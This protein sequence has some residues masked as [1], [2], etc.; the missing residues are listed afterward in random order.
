M[1]KVKDG[2]Q[3]A[4]EGSSTI[5]DGLALGLRLRSLRR[6]RRLTL[7]ALATQADCSESLLSR[8]ENGHVV[9]SLTT[10][11]RL[12]Q[13]LGINVGALLDAPREATCVVR[14]PGDRPS[15]VRDEAE[16]GDGSIAQSLIP[17]APGRQ[18][19]GLIVSLPADGRWCGPFVHEG[20]EVG[21]VLSG[22]LEL[23][24][25]GETYLVPEGSSFFFLSSHEH[26]YR[27]AERA[28]CRALWV[29]TPPNF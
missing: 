14:G 7:K 25:A 29:N 4:G 21:F 5:P 19:E 6:S 12:C 1:A 24:V 23:I 27:A 8:V 26:H 2:A 13:A 22:T 18:L 20:E 17:F 16:E 15:H 3:A 11:H 10:L 28:P 9:P